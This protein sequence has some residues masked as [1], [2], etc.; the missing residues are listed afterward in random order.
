[1]KHSNIHCEQ[2][3]SS[4]ENSQKALKIKEDYENDKQES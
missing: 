1:M 3:T 4:K 2:D